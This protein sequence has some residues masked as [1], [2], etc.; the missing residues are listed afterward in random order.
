MSMSTSLDETILKKLA[1]KRDTPGDILRTRKYVSYK[2][3]NWDVSPPV[4]LILLAREYN[5][6]FARYRKGLSKEHLAE[7]TSAL[8]RFTPTPNSQPQ[9]TKSIKQ[10]KRKKILEVVEYETADH[11][12][13]GHIQELNKAYTHG[14]Y[15]AVYILARKI[16][17]NLI[18]DILRKKFPEKNKENKELYFNTAQGRFKDFSEILKNLYDKR[19]EFGS[20]SKGVERLYSLARKLKDDANDKTHSW[21]H[22]VEQKSEIDS[23][24]LK[25]V[26]EIIKKLE[27]FVGIR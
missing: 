10:P 4:A 2:A 3:K 7:L 25:Q 18:I 14:C 13:K 24:N 12:I 11:F 16:I 9:S 17:E 15:T 19:G 8:N 22:L 20:E 5:I 26:I 6:G 23:L 27:S 21:Y 1:D